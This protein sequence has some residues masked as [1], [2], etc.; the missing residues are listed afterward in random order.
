MSTGT[1]SFT[2]E[3]GIL[4]ELGEQVFNLRGSSIIVEI[5]AREEMKTKSGL[6]IATDMNH[7]KGQSVNAHMVD[8]GVVLMTGP[9]YWNDELEV[10]VPNTTGVSFGDSGAIKRPGYEPLEVQPGAVVIMP[11]YSAQLLSHFP[12]IARPTN[13]KLA[14][15]KMDNVIAYYPTQF[16]YEQA[17]KRLNT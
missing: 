10:S 3:F 13:N 14:I 7:T 6:V 5:Q 11:Q 4:R 12:G 2:R 16:A 8:V 9:G 15:I 1:D 17:K